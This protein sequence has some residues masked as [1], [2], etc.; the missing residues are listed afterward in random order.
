MNELM[1]VT[2][3]VMARAP[4]PGRCKTRLAPM[5]GAAGAARLYEAMLRDSLDAFAGVGAS[6]LVVLAA[7]EDSGVAAL[8]SIASAAWEVIAQEGNDLGNVSRTQR[9]RSARAG[10]PSRSRAVTRPR[11]QLRRYARRSQRSGGL[12]ARCSGRAT[13]AGTI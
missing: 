8:R 7:P 3:G 6:R 11:L 9:R 5:L 13:T 10:T 4:V 1:G 2:L 12:G